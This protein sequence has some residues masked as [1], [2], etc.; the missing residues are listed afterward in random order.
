MTNK[1]P[2]SFPLW[3]EAL[4]VIVLLI[5]TV[6]EYQHDQW[7]WSAL[8]GLSALFFGISVIIRFNTGDKNARP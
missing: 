7:F 5:M 8:F 6:V 1:K 3:V 2:L 4:L